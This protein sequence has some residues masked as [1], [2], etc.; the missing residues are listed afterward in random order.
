MPDRIGD[1]AAEEAEDRVGDRGDDDRHR[2]EEGRLRRPVGDERQ[3][4]QGDRIAEPADDLGE[5]EERE[6][7]RAELEDRRGSVG[8][9]L[10]QDERDEEATDRDEDVTDAVDAV[11]HGDRDDVGE[12]PQLRLR[13]ERQVQGVARYGGPG[14]ADGF[15]V[16][17]HGRIREHHEHVQDGAQGD[18]RRAGDP[19][20]CEGHD[21]DAGEAGEVHGERRDRDEYPEDPQSGGD[22]EQGPEPQA[23]CR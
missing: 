3:R 5:P 9:R 2:G 18:Q 15:Q 16:E 14:G 11:H 12:E 20:V 17:R 10:D 19:P 4:D 21:R 22:R 7:G 23:E 1:R 8:F 13:T 6:V